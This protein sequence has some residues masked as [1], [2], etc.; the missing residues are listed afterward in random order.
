MLRRSC[1]TASK[2]DSVECRISVMGRVQVPL[3]WNG[4]ELVEGGNCE[5]TQTVA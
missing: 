5:S 1:F 4:L 3:G 2:K